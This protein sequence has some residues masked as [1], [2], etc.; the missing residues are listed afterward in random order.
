MPPHEV[1]PITFTELDE[2][3]EVVGATIKTGRGRRKDS[4]PAMDAAEIDRRAR[5]F[6]ELRASGL[7]QPRV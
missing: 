2:V 3:A 7:L 5:E 4:E 1:P 6:L